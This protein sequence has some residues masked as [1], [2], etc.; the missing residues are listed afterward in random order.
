MWLPGDG[1]P[2]VNADKE[3]DADITKLGCQDEPQETAATHGNIV[4][5]E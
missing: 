3:I 2:A 4:E 5:S 1:I